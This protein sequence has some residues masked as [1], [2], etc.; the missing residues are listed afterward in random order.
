MAQ[1]FIEPLARVFTNTGAVGAGY[2]YYFYTTGTT[3]P[4]SSYTTPALTIANP[5]PVVADANGRFP[6][7]WFSDLATTKIILTDAN[8]VVIETVDPVGTTGST[9]SLNDLDV[10]PTSY[11]GL[12][13]GTTSAYVLDANTS[14]STYSNVQ[15]IIFQSHIA[16]IAN[17]TIAISGL[18]ALNLKRYTGQ[19]TKTSLA[20]GDLQATQRYLAICD[21]IDIV[22]LNPTSSSQII[23]SIITWC[24]DIAPNGY[25]ECNGSA[26]SRTT[27][28]ALFSIIGTTFGIGDGST[29]FNIPDLRGYFVRGWSNGSSVDSGRSF[30]STQTDALQNITGI[31]GGLT[32]SIAAASGAF[33]YGSTYGGNGQQAQA[34][35]RL[36]FDASRVARTST[37]TRPTNLA[38][39]YCIKY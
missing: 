11:W 5:W 16:N 35:V 20:P 7:A 33:A 4:I 1:I 18:A 32:N 31:I 36:D 19:G 30:A 25:L 27:Y 28:A 24:A 2:K 21:G 23:G 12:T 14:I 3:T 26:I 13:T 8:D 9:T 6:I 22:V 37:E 38:L 15:T 17:P 39:M 10:R 29:T 34:N